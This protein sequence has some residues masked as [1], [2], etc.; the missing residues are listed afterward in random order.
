M[1]TWVSWEKHRRSQE[2]C[3]Y[4]GIENKVFASTRSRWLRHPAAIFN[5]LRYLVQQRPKTLIVQCPSIFLGLLA[6]LLKPVLGYKLIVDAHSDA[7]APDKKL[8]QQ[9][10]FLYRLIHRVADV[11]VVTNQENTGVVRES[12]GKAIVVPDRLF[13][14]PILEPKKL[15]GQHTLA[16]VCSFDVDEPYQEVFEAFRSF[17]ETTLYVTGRAPHH[18][19]EQYKTQNNLFFTGYTPLN[20]YLTLLASVDGILALTTRENTTLCA[21]NEAVSFTQPL[22]LS[23]TKF[24]RG[25]F[26]KGSVYTANTAEGIRTAYQTFLQE[27]ERLKT[28]MVAFKPQLSHAWEEKGQAFKDIVYDSANEPKR[29]TPVTN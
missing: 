10:F 18:V 1:I 23:N 7:V 8:V 4:L 13:T 14:P 11:V 28:E 5:T 16:F 22:I 21:A 19:L 17:P 15:K 27:R 6:C 2:L 9:F 3:A 29:T 25:Y 26:N 12:G 24:L 20:D